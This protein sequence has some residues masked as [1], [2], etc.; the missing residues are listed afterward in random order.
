MGHAAS[1]DPGASHLQ[2]SVAI[3]LY[4]S[5]DPVETP[6]TKTALGIS[7]GRTVYADHFSVLPV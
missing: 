2:I 6:K 5:Y 4:W 7:W 3:E 1:F